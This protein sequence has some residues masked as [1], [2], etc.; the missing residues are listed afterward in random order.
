V[1]TR[2]R[3]VIEYCHGDESHDCN[4]CYRSA[5]LDIWASSCE[6]K[7]GWQGVYIYDWSDEWHVFSFVQVVTEI[8]KGQ[9]KLRYSTANEQ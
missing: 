8:Q 7:V 6:C 9:L 3:I 1:I 5:T 4:G 2:D